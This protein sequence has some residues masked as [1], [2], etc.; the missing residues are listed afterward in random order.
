MSDLSSLTTIDGVSPDLLYVVVN[1]LGTNVLY[2]PGM[3]SPW[4]HPNKKYAESVAR[5]AGG[6]VLTLTEAIDLLAKKGI[7]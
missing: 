4:R 1:K 5:A 7:K 2:D 3:E 6:H